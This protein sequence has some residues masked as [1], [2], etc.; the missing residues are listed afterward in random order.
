MPEA[1]LPLAPTVP[2]RTAML[3]VGSLLR[4]NNNRGSQVDAYREADIPPGQITV[5]INHVPARLCNVVNR[6]L[7]DTSLLPV[8][9]VLDKLIAYP[10]WYQR[11]SLYIV[12]GG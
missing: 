6:M 12:T 10:S 3:A 4:A 8:F 7:V 5:D 1:V 11:C 9:C 2:G